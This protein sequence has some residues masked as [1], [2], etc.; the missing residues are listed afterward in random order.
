MN[1]NR[2]K[3]IGLLHAAAGMLALATVCVFMLSTLYAEAFGHPALV[4]TVKT[5]I[6]WGMPLLIL[7][8]ASIGGSGLALSGR[9]PKGHAARKVGRMKIAG[10]IGL[11][12]LAPASVF[13]A[14][15]A[16]A[17]SF[18]TAF[19]TVQ[20]IECIAGAINITLIA[21]NMRDGFAMTAGRR[22]RRFVSTAPDRLPKART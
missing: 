19:Y 5:G 12:V 1:Q 2:R 16:N 18:D 7:L 8:M 10:P 21:L 9:S 15:K 13:L 20:V 6:L 4:A 17:D 22:A 3:I 14:W 11:L